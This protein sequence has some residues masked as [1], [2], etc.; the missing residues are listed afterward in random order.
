ME[1]FQEDILSILDW[2]QSNK[3]RYRPAGKKNILQ[4]IWQ[5]LF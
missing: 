4:E 1:E 2:H 3:V 5:S